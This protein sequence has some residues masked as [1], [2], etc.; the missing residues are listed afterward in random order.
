M[1]QHNR[2]ARSFEYRVF[3]F[4]TEWLTDIG[5]FYHE[6]RH[7]DEQVYDNNLVKLLRKELDFKNEVVKFIFIPFLLYM[8]MCIYYFSKML[9]D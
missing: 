7:A 3:I 2:K 6:L 9:T 8:A 1:K 4:E 5:K